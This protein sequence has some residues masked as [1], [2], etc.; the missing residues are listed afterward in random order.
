MLVTAKYAAALL[1]PI[2]AFLVLSSCSSTPAGPQM[3]TPAFYWQAARKTFAQGDYM[4]TLEHLDRI[5]ATDNDY[6]AR[7][8]PW[9]L[10]LSS[11]MAAG[12][13]EMGDDYAIGARLNRVNPLA[14][15]KLTTNSRGFAN[16]LALQ[17][18]DDFGKIGKLK[19]GPVPLA[20]GYPRGTA[21]QVPA[22]LK[23]AGGVLI[24][25][26]EIETAQKQAVERG[27]LLMACR[28]AGAP[29]DTAKAQEVLKGP[30]GAVPRAT[31]LMAMAD[32][33]YNESQLYTRDKL[34]EPQKLEIFCQRA[35]DALKSVPDSKET[36]GLA[37]K[38]QSALKKSRKS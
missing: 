25:P 7:A 14:Y 22:L 5:L 11:G 13:M 23:A 15:R 17:F 18:A 20:F 37:A 38:I 6:T 26:A 10:V 16:R 4:K 24:S 36:K 30:D 9:S 29:D 1:A 34:D 19:E 12:Y 35:Q 31:F 27:V 33:L 32:A 3:G 2:S 8:L 28:A 21:A